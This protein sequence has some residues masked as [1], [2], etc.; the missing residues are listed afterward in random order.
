MIAIPNME[1]PKG[2]IDCP[3]NDMACELWTEVANIKAHKHKDCPLIE[4]AEPTETLIHD[5][6]K[7]IAFIDPHMIIAST[8]AEQIER[9]EA[10]KDWL[11]SIVGEPN[12]DQ[13]TQHVE[14]ALKRET[15]NLAYYGICTD[16]DCNKCPYE[17][18]EIDEPK[19]GTWVELNRNEDGTHNIQC[20]Y[21]RGCVKSKGH[22]NSF[23]TAKHFSYC[24]HCGAE[25]R[26]EF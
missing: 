24:P 3:V 2:C 7:L 9:A 10:V 16:G 8:Y 20:T 18:I 17:K 22:A 11:L 19:V 1:K 6:R 14:S 4:I 26:T 5:I 23:Y 21:C 13:N 15:C 25:M 12:A